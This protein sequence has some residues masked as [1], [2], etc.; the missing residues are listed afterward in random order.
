MEPEFDITIEGPVVYVYEGDETYDSMY[1]ERES[2][3]EV[4]TK[5]ERQHKSPLQRIISDC[6]GAVFIYF[7]TFILC[8]LIRTVREGQWTPLYWSIWGPYRYLTGAPL[9]T[10]ILRNREPKT[11]QDKY[12]DYL[13]DCKNDEILGPVAQIL[14]YMFDDDRKFTDAECE[15]M[16]Q[17]K[18]IH[19][20]NKGMQGDTKEMMCQRQADN[21]LI[22]YISTPHTILTSLEVITD[23]WLKIYNDCLA[24]EADPPDG[25]HI[26]DHQQKKQCLDYNDDFLS[27][28]YANNPD[29][30]DECD[31]IYNDNIKACNQ[32]WDDIQ[33]CYGPYIAF[34]DCATSEYAQTYGIDVYC[35]RE[36]SDLIVCENSS[37]HSY[38][39][40]G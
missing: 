9:I 17:I 29:K 5:S 38:N 1:E 4:T 25:E 21:W 31:F 19:C 27:T 30:H 6:L 23:N 39:N 3:S 32:E 40:S 11:C 28:C 16:A 26:D 18:L 36:K 2:F 12:D 7:G 20:Q 14:D 13:K 22:E 10:R 24:A 33:G 34:A 15:N 35:E 37:Y 8:D